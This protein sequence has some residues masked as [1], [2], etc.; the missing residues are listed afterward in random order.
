M[1]DRNVLVLLQV[2]NHIDA[3]TFP[4]VVIVA[5]RHDFGQLLVIVWRQPQ[6]RCTGTKGQLHHVFFVV[7]RSLLKGALSGSVTRIKRWIGK[8]LNWI[9]QAEHPREEP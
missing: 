1:V 6:R 2:T 4:V 8:A 3:D 9:S 5:V 7:A